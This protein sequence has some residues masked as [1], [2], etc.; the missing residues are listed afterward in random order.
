MFAIECYWCSFHITSLIVLFCFFSFSRC[1]KCNSILP[2]IREENKVFFCFYFVHIE[3]SLNAM[4]CFI[5]IICW[6]IFHLILY[7]YVKQTTKSNKGYWIVQASLQ[8]NFWAIKSIGLTLFFKKEK[9]NRFFSVR[10]IKWDFI[11]H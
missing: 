6:T 2:H 4:K 5:I 9:K 10:V 8:V 1:W 7:W 11:F 3:C